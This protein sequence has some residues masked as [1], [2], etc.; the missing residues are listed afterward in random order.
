MLEGSQNWQG[1]Q[2]QSSIYHHHWQKGIQYL[3]VAIGDHP[4]VHH[5]THQLHLKPTQSL[6]RPLPRQWP[7]THPLSQKIS[8]Q[9]SIAL[10]VLHWS[11]KVQRRQPVGRHAR[12]CQP[13]HLLGAGPAPKNRRFGPLLHLPSHRLLQDQVLRETP[14]QVH[15]PPPS[16]QQI[17]VPACYG[18]LTQQH[19]L[20]QHQVIDKNRDI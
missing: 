9:K 12:K 10:Q 7:Q 6:I 5:Q 14:T 16:H 4:S 1:I 8:P 18:L 19:K 11:L 15:S 20:R 13:Q 2:Q 3:Q 17:R